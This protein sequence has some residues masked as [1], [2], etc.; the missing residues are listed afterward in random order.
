MG[1]LFVPDM[2]D[3]RLFAIWDTLTQSL[4]YQGNRLVV[5]LG[6]YYWEVFR[7]V[8]MQHDK[9][10]TPWNTIVCRHRS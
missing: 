10:S 6:V 2:E 5:S 3:Y 4:S 7:N 8:V 9:E 1:V